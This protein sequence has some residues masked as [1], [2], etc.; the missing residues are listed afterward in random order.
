MQ[1]VGLPDKVARAVIEAIGDKQMLSKL[2]QD[3]LSWVS[4][5]SNNEDN[6][7]FQLYENL[8][9]SFSISKEQFLLE[10]PYFDFDKIIDEIVCEHGEQVLDKYVLIFS[11]V[12]DKCRQY[13][14]SDDEVSLHT[15][16]IKADDRLY[17]LLISALPW[18]GGISHKTLGIVTNLELVWPF[19]HNIGIY[20]TNEAKNIPLENFEEEIYRSVKLYKSNL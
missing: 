11:L 20:N 1:I 10:K 7:N 6:I 5:D 19:L 3:L 16:K 8:D 2:P 9:E 4:G 13:E 17:Y 15:F 18:P 14:P 12:V